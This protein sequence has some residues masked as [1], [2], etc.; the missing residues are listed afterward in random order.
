MQEPA[1]ARRILFVPFIKPP[2]VGRRPGSSYG[3]KN[4]SWMMSY[5]AKETKKAVMEGKV[6]HDILEYW[7]VPH[8]P[9]SMIANLG[10]NDQ[11]Y[12]RGH[13]FAGLEG[14]F[15]HAA[16]DEQGKAIHQSKVDKE[17]LIKLNE[18]NDSGTKKL[19]FMLK[20]PDVVTRLRESGLK[21]EFA[22]TI[23]CYNCHSAEGDT[24]FATALEKALSAGGYKKC[25]IYGYTG[26]LS[27]M[28]E[29][30]HKTSDSRNTRARDARVEIKRT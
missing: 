14:I 17:L 27:S 28:Y 16:Q 4:A 26:A 21:E 29:G 6:A 20:A 1:M 18:D 5:N 23:K 7:Y 11:L 25:R 10:P 8:T 9:N 12:I 3:V 15:D 30:D 19:A 24:N 13:S 2:A 22:G